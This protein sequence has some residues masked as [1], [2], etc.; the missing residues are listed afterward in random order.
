MTLACAL[1]AVAVTAVGTP[2]AVAKSLS[3]IVTV[4][5]LGELNV[6]PVGEDNVIVNVSSPSIKASLMIG[7][8]IVLFAT[9][10]FAQLSIP[11]CMVKS[12]GAVAVPGTVV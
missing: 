7:T 6:A 2:G 8:V 12:L 5:V 3:M 10:P 4:I 1:P 9:S 11:D